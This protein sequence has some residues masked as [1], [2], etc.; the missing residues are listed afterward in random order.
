MQSSEKSEVSS[1]EVDGESEGPFPV[2][3]V[4]IVEHDKFEHS[5]VYTTASQRTISGSNKTKYNEVTI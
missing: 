4:D 1:T 3:T 5:S 2:Q